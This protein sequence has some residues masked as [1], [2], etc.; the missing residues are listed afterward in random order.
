MQELVSFTR[1]PNLSNIGTSFYKHVAK[2]HWPPSHSAELHAAQPTNILSVLWVSLYKNTDC[3]KVLTRSTKW[4]K[5]EN[6]PLYLAANQ[7]DA[8]NK[9]LFLVGLSGEVFLLTMES[10][11]RERPLDTLH[12]AIG[13]FACRQSTPAYSILSNQIEWYRTVIL[14]QSNS[15]PNHSYLLT[16]LMEKYLIQ[17]PIF[18][19]CISTK[20]TVREL[21][22]GWDPWIYMICLVEYKASQH[23]WRKS[24]LVLSNE[25][26]SYMLR[27]LK[28]SRIRKTENFFRAKQVIS[29]LAATNRTR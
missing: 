6:W 13:F 9:L 18:S 3:K 11:Y 21:T 24:S 25:W 2:K 26:G 7:L 29:A 1:L 8:S 12:T 16:K 14:T 17:W 10:V 4:G 19:L 23:K 28:F 27:T 5:L 15:L 20:I 22:K